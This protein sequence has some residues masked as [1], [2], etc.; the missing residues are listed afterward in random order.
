MQQGGAATSAAPLD[1]RRLVDAVRSPGWLIPAVLLAL[2]TVGWAWS[3]ATAGSMSSGSPDLPA[4]ADSMAMGGGMALMAFPGFMLAWLAM[5]TAMMLPAISPVVRLYGLTAARGRAAPVPFFVA[6]YLVVWV[7]IG[8]PAFFAWRALADPL[9][10]GDAWVGRLA[11]LVLLSAAV[12]QVTPLKSACLR[13]CRSPL[14]FFLRQRGDLRR[15]STALRMGTTHGL[16]CLGCCWMLMAI[17]VTLG[18][19]QIVAMI[20]LAALILVEKNARRGAVLARGAAVAMLGL[21]VPLLVHPDLV[22]H[23]T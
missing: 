3:L 2:A 6:G 17:L 1:R 7:S 13:H 16:I 11:G 14:G 10:R 4:P 19:M 21:A 12:Y 20:I 5:M 15:P 9:A 23:L 18:T 22:T 8:V